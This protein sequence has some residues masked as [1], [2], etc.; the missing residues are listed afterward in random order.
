MV[1]NLMLKFDG[2]QLA[3]GW[4][5]LM[6]CLKLQVSF[7]ERVL[8]T[9]QHTATTNYRTLTW[10]KTYRDTG[11]RRV[12]GCIIF[13]GLFPQKSPTNGGSFVKNYLQLKASYGP[14]PPCSQLTEDNDF[15]NDFWEIK[16]TFGEFDV[17]MW[18]DEIL[19]NLWRQDTSFKL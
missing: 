8:H 3:T 17:E 16:P 10:K 18:Y 12:R 19:R 1:W 5:R 2:K 6:R 14:S 11:W 13:T 7:L 9:L 15:K 4:P